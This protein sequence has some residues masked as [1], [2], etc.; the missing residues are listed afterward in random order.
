MELETS[1]VLSKVT[2]TVTTSAATDKFIDDIRNLKDTVSVI[3]N[4]VQSLNDELTSVDNESVQ[5]SQSLEATE[6]ILSTTQTSIEESNNL[7]TA[8]TT[9]VRILQQDLTILKQKY[10]DQQ[11]SSYDGVLVWKIS[12]FQEKMSKNIR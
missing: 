10:E 7:L 1:D 12:R 9:N 3:S 8:M 2:T 11:V 6:K 4:G 5:Q